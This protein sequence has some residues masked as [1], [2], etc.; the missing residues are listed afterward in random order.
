MSICVNGEETPLETPESVASL[1]SRWGYEGRFAVALNGA[2]V[3][4]ATYDQTLV[5][6]GDDIEIVAPMRGG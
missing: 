1:V 6:P 3:P 2:L 4:R 5:R